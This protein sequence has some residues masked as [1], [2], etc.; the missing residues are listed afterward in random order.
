[1]T[2]KRNRRWNLFDLQ[3]G[4]CYYCKI[5]LLLHDQLNPRY[6]TIDHKVPRIKGGS[7]KSD[8]IVLCC[9]KCNKEKGS[10]TAEEYELKILTQRIRV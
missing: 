3:K 10:M 4:V 1:M 7:G 2:I 9:L 6:A 5:S 8:N